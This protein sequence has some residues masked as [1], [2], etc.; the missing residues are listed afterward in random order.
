LL[1]VNVKPLLLRFN[2]SYFWGGLQKGEGY[3][4]TYEGIVVHLG[5]YLDQVKDDTYN[6]CSTANKNR[7]KSNIERLLKYLETMPK[8]KIAWEKE[9]KKLGVI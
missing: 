5:I 9:F 2:L 6:S 4:G 1:Q 7:I 3:N 8:I